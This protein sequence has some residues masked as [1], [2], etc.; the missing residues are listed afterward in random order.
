MTMTTRHF[1]VPRKFWDLKSSTT[2]WTQLGVSSNELLNLSTHSI[3]SNPD[4][5]MN[6]FHGHST[7]NI[8]TLH[9]QLTLLFYLK[10]ILFQ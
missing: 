10:S 3:Q 7:T 4:T 9:R 1:K 2:Q 6:L 5:L 8:V